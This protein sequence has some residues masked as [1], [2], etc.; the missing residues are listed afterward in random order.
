MPQLHLLGTGASI[1]DPHRTTTMLAVTDGP[2]TVV[3]DCGGDVV[4]RLL[5]A[6]IALDTIE[7]LIITHEH[8]D[9]VG[10]FPLFMEKIWLAPR[11]RP[12]PIYGIHAALDQA[13]RTFATFD[14]STWE[15]LPERI[16]HE[17]PH[18]PGALVLEDAHWRITAAPV[19]HPVPNIGLR[20]ESKTSGGVVAYSCDTEPTPSVV[21]LGREADLLVHE[22][23]GYLPGVHSSPEQAARV[24]REA[25]ARR[26]LLVHLP[27]GLTEADLAEARAHFAATELG[28]ELGVY[29]F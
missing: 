11:R 20:I 15:G 19:V 25:Q 13:R 8:P 28:E 2:S 14:T 1:S 9:H 12:I 21:E 24:A 10:G 27:P 23:N 18:T 16:W 26:L 5:A 6:G 17:V 22:A 3:I 7:A 29:P 4:Q